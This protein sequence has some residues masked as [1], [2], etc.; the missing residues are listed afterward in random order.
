MI[1]NNRYLMLQYKIYYSKFVGCKILT[2]NNV[3]TETYTV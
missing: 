2:D 3:I 1:I